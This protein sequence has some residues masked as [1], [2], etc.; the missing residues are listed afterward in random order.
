M[1]L[2]DTSERRAFALPGSTLHYGPD[3]TV[4]VQH[5][6]LNLIPDVERRRLEGICTTTVRALD[7]PVT[8]L[9]LDA[10]DLKIS[11]V[12]SGGR[13]L[14][15]TPRGDRLDVHFDPPLAPEATATFAIA[16][17]VE[18]PRHGLFFVEPSPEY[19]K[20]I[21]HAWS[22]CQDENARYWFPCLDYPHE[23]QSTSATIAVPKGQFALGNGALIERRDEGGKTIFRYDQEIPHSTYLV[24]MV[25]GPFVEVAQTGASVPIYYYVLPGREA[26]GERSFGKTPKMMN[27]FEERLDCPYPY[28][29]Y[30]QIAVSDFIFGGMENTSATTQTDRT[31]HDERAHLDFSS[32]PLVAHELAH[33]WFGDLLTCRDWSQAWLNESFATFFEG[34]FRE[35]DLG[36][37]EY[38]YDVFEWVKRYLDEDRQRYRR[39]IVCNDYRDPIELFDRHLYEK[40]GAV[41]HML[42]G[43]LGEARFWRALR[44]YVRNNA[45]RSVETIDLIRA[46][47]QAT[48][49]NM[50]AFFDRWIFGGGH[51]Q[52]RIGATYDA[53]RH[54]LTI[55]IDQTQPIDAQNPPFAFGVDVEVDGRR[56]RV[57]VEREHETIAVPLDSEPTLVRFDP[58]AFILG[59]VTY[60]LGVRFSSA[61]LASDASVVARIRAGCE[62]VKDGS[63]QA[64]TAVEAAL[65]SDAFWGV[66]AE[67]ATALGKTQAA[68][69][70]DLLLAA[71][72]H[73]HP[74]VRRAVAGALGEFREPAVAQALIVPATGDASY[75]VQRAALNALGKTRSEKAFKVLRD[76]ARTVSWNGVIESG[77]ALGLGELADQRATPLLLDLTKPGGDVATRGAA[78]L[79]LARQAELLDSERAAAVDA[80]AHA[81]GDASFFISRSGV[82]AAEQLADKRF[83]APLD[84]L[85]QTGF[86]GRLR[87]D[88]ADAAARIRDAQKT[89]AAVTGLRTDLDAL[90][91]E[92]RKL[93]E[94]LDA[95]SRV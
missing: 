78:L 9:T 1:S 44:H 28:A 91:E 68:W 18:S 70:R 32:D 29:R 22:Q 86:D 59:D 56:I 16:Y 23:K 71:L 49:R 37:D 64:R 19:P 63:G 48:G 31:L 79:A 95:I 12:E 62:L 36:Y 88:A 55:T 74:K 6:D 61:A 4:D 89:P 39:P 34:V 84:R 90:R 57:Q 51:P 80:I 53:Q 26:D 77:A 73:P 72:A 24:T 15:F 92:H 8:T 21:R 75:F 11:S 3:K 42:R 93:Q 47:E 33:Q 52:L 83:L 82:A 38:I 87:R 94:K 60:A 67:L 50:R 7:E 10:V 58:G 66:A 20:K 69:A 2:D 76:A 13:K 14:T 43:E 5:I 54:A 40:G 35:A 65:K 30:S 27:V 85:A 46:I 25:T 81:I 45:Q 17:S 41:L